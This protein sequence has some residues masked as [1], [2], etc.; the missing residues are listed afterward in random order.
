MRRSEIARKDLRSMDSTERGSQV[1]IGTLAMILGAVED[2]II[3]VNRERRIVLFNEAA[4]QVFGYTV[5][6][7]R[8]KTVDVLLPSGFVKDRGA[9]VV[10]FPTSARA[11]RPI[12][13][14]QEVV[15][16]R[17]DGEHFQAQ[18]SISQFGDQEAW[19][20]AIILREITSGPQLVPRGFQSRA[21][22]DTPNHEVSPGSQDQAYPMDLPGEGLSQSEPSC[23]ERLPLAGA[24]MLLEGLP[25]SFIASS[26][27]MR[28]LLIF[29]R[30]V[31]ASEACTILIEGESGVGKDVLARFIHETSRRRSNAFV[32][33][34]CA[35]I[36]E[37]LLESELFG[38]E[39][40]AFTDARNQKRGILEVASGGT[41]FLDEIGELP[42]TLQAKL[43]R[44]L[45]GHRFRRLGGTKDLEVDLRVITAT[46]RDLR[47]AIEHGSFRA[48]LYY[49]LNVIQTTIPPLRDRKDDIMPLAEHFIALYRRKFRRDV[50]GFAA[51]ALSALHAHTWPGNIRELRN[52]IE[53]AMLMQDGDWIRETDLGIRG[54]SPVRYTD[55]HGSTGDPSLAAVERIMLIGA[56]NKAEWNQT[57]ASEL[58]KISR[59]TLRYRMK[60]FNLQP[61]ARC[62]AP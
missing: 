35:A 48:D 10:E 24:S 22:N 25:T 62:L 8:G 21:T 13:L 4:E 3:F 23:S 5:D 1:S 49:R 45:E 46:N 61:P 42:L 19:M 33:V 59:D 20:L 9:P 38:Y 30:R 15:A 17:K 6:E 60:K 36:P 43:L 34:N 31:A 40:G 52:A 26:E 53:R 11:S 14:R 27:S 55:E 50:K 47:K 44:V 56:L 18:A 39:K 12:P 29:A 32:A 7:I 2:A 54:N 28:Q 51:D 57:R 41:M 58:L 16:R 37:A